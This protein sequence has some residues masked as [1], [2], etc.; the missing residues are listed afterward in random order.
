MQKREITSRREIINGGN[1]IFFDT[2][3]ELRLFDEEMVNGGITYW[4]DGSV[5]SLQIL[6]LLRYELVMLWVA[7]AIIR[8]TTSKRCRLSVTNIVQTPIST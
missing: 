7:M 4:S 5:S 6:Y 8:R 2:Y 3:Y 1:V